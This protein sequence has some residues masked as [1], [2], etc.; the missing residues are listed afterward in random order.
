MFL[1]NVAGSSPTRSGLELVPMMGGMLITSIVSGQ[2]ISRYGKYKRFPILGTL[3]MTAGLLMLSRLSASTTRVEIATGMLVL[4]LGFGMIMQVLIIAVQNAVQFRDI[5]VATSGA[6]LFRLVGGSV[7]TAV[8]GVIFSSRLQGSL[9]G[10][11]SSASITSLSALTPQ[12]IAA[13]D[14]VT[15]AALIDGFTRATD[16]IFLVAAA[17]GALGFVFV[18]MM[19]ELPLRASVAAHAGEVDDEVAEAIGM[20]QSAE[21]TDDQ[22]GDTSARASR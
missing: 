18:W 7:G 19:P 10:A 22:L 13:L 17:I 12:K 9:A 3:V 1:Q 20:P 11:G 2:I 16:T 6:T 15:H 14:P 4:G 5:G 8:L 21:A